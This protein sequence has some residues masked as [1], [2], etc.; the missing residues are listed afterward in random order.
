MQK[1]YHQ[2][3]ASML[4]VMFYL[5]VCAASTHI[6][7]PALPDLQFDLNT[8]RGLSQ[9]TISI[10]LLGLA[11]CQFF[12]GSFSD[13]YGRRLTLIIGFSI[14][15]IG[16]LI[17]YLSQNIETLLIARFLQGAGAASGVAMMRAALSDLFSGAKLVRVSTY[18]MMLFSIVPAL[19]PVI[20]GYIV[21]LSGWRMVFLVLLAL[22]FIC[23]MLIIFVWQETNKNLD[24]Q[25]LSLPVMRKNYG[26]LL[27]QGSFL[28]YV[29]LASL[30]TSGVIAYIT[31]S[32]HL[33]QVTLNLSAVQYGWMVF[34]TGST[35]L[36]GNFFNLK[37][38]KHYTRQ[39]ILLAGLLLIIVG[40]LMLFIGSHLG[41]L[42]VYSIVPAVFIYALGGSVVMANSFA[43]ALNMNKHIAGTSGALF[44]T[45]Q[46]AMSFIASVI[47]TSFNPEHAKGLGLYLLIIAI[48]NTVIFLVLLYQPSKSISANVNLAD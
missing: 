29:A 35:L 32:P 44:G 34:L 36:I 24:A 6:F 22:F 18:F 9:L 10:Y 17:A 28:G 40:A 26:Y 2:P 5:I 46:T 7:S 21:D 25:A 33:L 23:L 1:W 8:S 19:T 43:A 31:F 4:M 38:I 47:A 15:T 13:Q 27:R 45:C 39:A 16:S 12:Y 41:W 20:G 11:T 37:L 14:A 42:S 48:V 3:T 30:T